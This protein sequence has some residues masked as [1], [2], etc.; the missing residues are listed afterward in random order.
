MKK[1]YIRCTGCGELYMLGYCMEDGTVELKYLASLLEWLH[2][3]AKDSYCTLSGI[4]QPEHFEFVV[5]SE[6]LDE[7]THVC[8]SHVFTGDVL[9]TSIDGIMRKVVVTKLYKDCPDLFYCTIVGTGEKV[10][11][12]DTNLYRE[13]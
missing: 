10:K 1:F 5:G 7:N 4:S 9:Y 3:H 2:D 12:Y 11:I 6:D 8:A 13:V